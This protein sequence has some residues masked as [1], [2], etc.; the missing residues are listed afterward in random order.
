[1]NIELLGVDVETINR[2]H[3]NMPEGA[4]CVHNPGNGWII[5]DGRLFTEKNTDKAVHYL[6]SL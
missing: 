5:I 6:L 1:M 3:E 4:N 2:I